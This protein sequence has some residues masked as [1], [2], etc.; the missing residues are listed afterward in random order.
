VGAPQAR[1]FGV[2]VQFVIL[3]ITSTRL[4]SGR[5]MEFFSQHPA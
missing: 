4:G 1:L 3:K 5:Q 2:I